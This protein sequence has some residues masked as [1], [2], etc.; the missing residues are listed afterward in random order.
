MGKSLKW[1]GLLFLLALDCTTI[2]WDLAHWGYYFGDEPWWL[3]ILG[4]TEILAFNGGLVWVL[5]RLSRNSQT[6]K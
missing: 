5:F 2:G 3:I 6:P 1:W 4:F